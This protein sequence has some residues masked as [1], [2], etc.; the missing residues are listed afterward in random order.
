MEDPHQPLSSGDMRNGR[1]FKDC[2]G[3]VVKNG[4]KSKML[5]T[6]REDAHA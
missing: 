2:S 4:M 6:E 3:D 1:G 5:A